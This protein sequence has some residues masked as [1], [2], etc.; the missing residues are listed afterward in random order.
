MIETVTGEWP[1]FV[2]SSIGWAMVA[3]RAATSGP[4]EPT[5]HPAEPSPPAPI[6]LRATI[7]IDI[8]AADLDKAE[9]ETAALH[10]RL[11]MLKEAH[12]SAELAIR[13][14]KPRTT[15]RAPTPSRVVAYVDD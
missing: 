5:P 2:E 6:R 9:Q 8:D 11:E 10:A 13:R 12:P 15:A 14:R 7:T 4:A 1:M 3:A